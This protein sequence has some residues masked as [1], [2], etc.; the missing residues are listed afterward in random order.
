[1]FCE[2]TRPFDTKGVHRAV[3]TTAKLL[4]TLDLLGQEYG[5]VMIGGRVFITLVLPLMGVANFTPACESFFSGSGS[6][7]WELSEYLH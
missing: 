1:M 6:N 5:W 4:L 2:G 7:D 3:W